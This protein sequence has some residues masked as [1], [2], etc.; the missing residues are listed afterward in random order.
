MVFSYINNLDYTIIFFIEF[1]KKMELT[2][3]Q[4]KKL[5]QK[6]KFYYLL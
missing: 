5:R 1:L 2:N 4:T 6:K 3:K